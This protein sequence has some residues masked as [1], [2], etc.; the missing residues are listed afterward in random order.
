MEL[1]KVF[2]YYDHTKDIFRMCALS[3]RDQIET[4]ACNM[5]KSKYCYSLFN[6]KREI[7]KV[8]VNAKSWIMDQQLVNSIYNVSERIYKSLGLSKDQY[9]MNSK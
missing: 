9:L 8:S 4:M 6:N 1:A 5:S 7:S 3:S 2:N